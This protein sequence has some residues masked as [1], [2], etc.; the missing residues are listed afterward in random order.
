MPEQHLRCI[1]ERGEVAGAS[2]AIGHDL[3]LHCTRVSLHRV[4]EEL[5]Y[6]PRRVLNQIWL[7]QTAHCSITQ[8][9]GARWFRAW[10]NGGDCCK[11]VL[12]GP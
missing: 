1:A 4:L 8:S 10:I 2:H 9:L 5:E 12:F 6:V 3:A 11:D 7:G